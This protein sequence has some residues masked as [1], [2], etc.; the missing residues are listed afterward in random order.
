MA[1]LVDSPEF[2]DN[3]VYLIQQSDRLEGAASGASFNG[4]GVSNQPHQQLANRTA[5]LK[6]RQDVNISNI[7]ILQSFMAG[8]RGLLQTDGYV[9]IPVADVSR[10]STAAIIQWGF[11]RLGS[12]TIGKDTEYSLA[13]PIAFPNA[14]LLPPWASNVY[15]DSGGMSVTAS[16]VSWNTRG[17]IFV[18]DVPAALH[19]QGL[20]GQETTGGFAWLAIGF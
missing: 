18:L 6:Q 3:E 14:I 15:V 4:I 8:F 1:T 19:S 13:W 10:G 2:T 17:G 5:L 7:S 20:A 11:F 9:I 16:P 12:V